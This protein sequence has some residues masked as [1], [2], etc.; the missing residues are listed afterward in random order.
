MVG[1]MTEVALRYYDDIEEGYYY[2]LIWKEELGIKL[3]K[4]TRGVL[5]ILWGKLVGAD[6]GKALW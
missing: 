4:P 2:W 5:V 1:G 3:G 6:K